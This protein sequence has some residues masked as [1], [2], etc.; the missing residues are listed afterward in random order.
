MVTRALLLAAALLIGCARAASVGERAPD[1]VQSLARGAPLTVITFF[2]AHCPCQRAHDER[3]RELHDAYAPRGVRFVAVDVEVG[4]SRERDDA[5]AK[6]RG[7]PFPLVPD[8]DG[9]LADALGAEAATFTVVVD[10]SGRVRF[11]GGI[12]SDRSHLT[13]TAEPW[14]REALDDLLAGREPRRAQTK[15]LGCSLERR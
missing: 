10:A 15:A 2:S 12:D 8:P 5:E 13:T 7:Y 6:A 1:R 3:L 11:A 4:A 14:L 9:D